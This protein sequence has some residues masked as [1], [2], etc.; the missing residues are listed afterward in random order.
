MHVVRLVKRRRSRNN[1]DLVTGNSDQGSQTDQGDLP[2]S[3]SDLFGQNPGS[4]ENLIGNDRHGNLSLVNESGHVNVNRTSSAGN[5]SLSRRSENFGIYTI[6]PRHSIS[7]QMTSVSSM[8]DPVNNTSNQSAFSRLRFPGLHLS[9][10][11]MFS[12]S[13]NSTSTAPSTPTSPDLSYIQTPPP[14]YIDAM[15][16]L[17]IEKSKLQKEELAETK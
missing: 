15:K 5:D 16:I 13:L 10:F 2:P 4:Q 12:T 6:L 8:E 7:E 11:D 9:I 3:Y 1:P 14:T 17:E